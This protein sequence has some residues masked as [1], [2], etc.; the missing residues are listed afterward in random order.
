MWNIFNEETE[1]K[2]NSIPSRILD[3]NAFPDSQP[4]EN[5]N[6]NKNEIQTQ[7]QTQNQ[8]IEEITVNKQYPNY[9]DDFNKIKYNNQ[10][11]PQSQ[12]NINEKTMNITNM[13]K[14]EKTIPTNYYHQFNNNSNIQFE[15][16]MKSDF[17][18]FQNYTVDFNANNMN[19][20]GSYPY[21]ANSTSNNN[22]SE[23]NQ[24]YGG[25]TI[26]PQVNYINFNQKMDPNYPGDIKVKKEIATT[27]ES[28]MHQ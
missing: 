8:N 3:T 24:L 11:N 1:I 7:E 25:Q 6:Q 13:N 15:P 16:P 4:P 23:N 20:I 19:N 27:N 14:V 2:L 5:E 17:N 18:T 21:N 28:C 9:K 12:Y 10:N 22:Q 26:N